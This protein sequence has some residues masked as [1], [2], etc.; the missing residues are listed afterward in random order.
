MKR[1]LHK[2]SENSLHEYTGEYT[3]CMKH[4]DEQH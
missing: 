1:K 3:E 2:N 4:T